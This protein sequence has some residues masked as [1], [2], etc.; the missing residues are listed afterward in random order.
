MALASHI[1]AFSVATMPYAD[2]GLDETTYKKKLGY[3]LT[4]LR[5]ARGYKRQGDFADA[6]RSSGRTVLRW[7]NGQTAPTA[8][9]LRL[10]SDVLEVPISTFMDPP[11][12]LDFGDLRISYSAEMTVR[13]EMLKRQQRRHRAAEE[14]S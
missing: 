3:V 8:W 4:Q 11:D 7:E 1:A 12:E 2:D 5:L 10:I 9:E 13:R 6:I 14:P